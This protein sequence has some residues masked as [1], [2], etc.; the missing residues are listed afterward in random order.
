MRTGCRDGATSGK[1]DSDDGTGRDSRDAGQAVG[2]ERCRETTMRTGREDGTDSTSG[3]DSRE[4]AMR[5]GQTP[6]RDRTVGKLM[7]GS[8]QTATRAGTGVS[9]ARSLLLLWLIDRD[10]IGKR[11]GTKGG[12]WLGA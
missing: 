8:G 6:R 3:R 10:G 2:K 12:D 5:T 7:A 9:P 4:E 11:C 1:S